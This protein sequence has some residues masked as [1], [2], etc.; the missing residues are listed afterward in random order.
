MII[1]NAINKKAYT[2]YTSISLEFVVD[3]DENV[4]HD[5]IVINQG[6]QY[7]YIHKDKLSELVNCCKV[8]ETID[9]G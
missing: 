2:D 9:K 5:V 1:N 6:D 4:D 3:M 8:Y 7:I